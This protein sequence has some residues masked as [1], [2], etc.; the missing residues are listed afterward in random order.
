MAQH[1]TE[2]LHEAATKLEAFMAVS[3]DWRK[4]AAPF[5]LDPV[6]VRRFPFGESVITGVF[7]RGIDLE[8]VGDEMLPTRELRFAGVVEDT[9]EVVLFAVGVRKNDA[10]RVVVADGAIDEIA[11]PGHKVDAEKLTRPRALRRGAE[12]VVMWPLP[13]GEV[14]EMA[15]EEA[16]QVTGYMQRLMEEELAALIEA[17]QNAPKRQLADP[18]SQGIIAVL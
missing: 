16:E 10:M 15:D 17:R 9:R 4:E 7:K 1:N 8:A 12:S 13:E 6:G 5:S 3:P 18:T 11:E 14:A 2:A